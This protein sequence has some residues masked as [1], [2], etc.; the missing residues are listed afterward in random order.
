MKHTNHKSAAPVR[1]FLLAALLAC[2]LP[3]AAAWAA[4]TDV[5]GAGTLLWGF[6]GTDVDTGPTGVTELNNQAGTAAGDAVRTSLGTGGGGQ[7]QVQTVDTGSGLNLVV[8]FDGADDTYL[9][10]FDSTITDRHQIFLVARFDEDSGESFNNYIIDGEDNSGRRPTGVRGTT[11]TYFTGDGGDIVTTIPVAIGEW[12]VFALSLG[13]AIQS[14]D[15]FTVTDGVTTSSFIAVTDTSGHDMTGLTVGGR[16][17]S[18]SA[19][20]RFNGLIAE[21]LVYNSD[22]SAADIAA[23]MDHLR[24]KYLTATGPTLVPSTDVMVDDTLGTTFDS[25]SNV[26]YRLQSTPDLVSSNFTETGAVVFGNGQAMT[27]FDPTGPS[28]SK[29]YRVTQE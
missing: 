28:T 1:P 24:D 21:I 8:A 7:A 5:T 26:V 17:A 22:L 6:D 2:A 23:V 4:V 11:G 16:T 12:R 10:D 18:P 9:S 19:V 25:E 15:I 27:L 20:N 3:G 14:N 29:N 13:S